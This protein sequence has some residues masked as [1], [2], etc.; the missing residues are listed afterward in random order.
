MCV[1]YLYSSVRLCIIYAVAFKRDSDGDVVDDVVVDS[2]D[3]DDDSAVGSS[4]KIAPGSSR[5]K[6]EAR[7]FRCSWRISA[8][9]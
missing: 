1:R 7:K 8:C 4:E 2:D 3:G 5:L 6:L 9:S